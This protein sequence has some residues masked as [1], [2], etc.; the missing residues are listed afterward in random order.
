MSELALAIELF[1]GLHTN[2]QQERCFG[3]AMGR[4]QSQPL[5]QKYPYVGRYT[6]YL[7][8]VMLFKP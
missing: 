2:K 5:I 8:G 7:L 6:L 3:E 4:Y 1:Q